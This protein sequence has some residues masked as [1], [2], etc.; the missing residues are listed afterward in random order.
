MVSRSVR[1]G[2]AYLTFRE[3]EAYGL[4][5]ATISEMLLYTE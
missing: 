3:R 5:Q 1:K 4:D 2:V